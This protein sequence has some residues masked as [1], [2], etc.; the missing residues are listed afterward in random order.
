MKRED[1]EFMSEL[2]VAV[3]LR[4]V[5][6]SNFL[7]FCV[8]ALFGW[9]LLWVSYAEIEER[10]RGTGQ[11]MA[12]SDMQVIQSL[13]GGILAE[14][15]VSEGDQVKKGQI[16]MRI[17]DVLF[18]SEGRGIEAQMLSLRAKQAR[19]KAEAKGNA[20]DMP[21]DI[22]EKAPAIAAN[23]IKLYK[24]RAQELKNMLDISQSEIR[25]VQSNLA[26]VN[27]SIGK[28]GRSRDL[29]KKEFNIAV[30]LVAKHAM[31]EIEKIRLERSLNEASGDLA[32]AR[33]SARGF[34]AKLSATKQKMEEKKT[35]LTSKTLGELGEVET[36]IATIQQSLNS[37]EDRVDRTELRAPV[38]GIVQR[39]NLK[40]VGGVVEPAQRL[41]E[42]VP[43]EDDLMIRAKV[44]PADV[45]FLRPGQK[46]R[47]GITAYDPQI[48][49]SLT[50]V[51]E[52]ISADT[53]KDSDGNVF[54]EIDVRTDKNYLGH[55]DERLRIAPGMVADT[56]IITGK[57]TILT[58]LLKPLLR[59]RDRAFSER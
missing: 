19:L 49:G 53:V 40:T 15:M 26:E 45:A 4:P 1:L 46:V 57:R 58:Y 14:L 48:Y 42:V 30:R 5:F 41:I 59:A 10:T 54:F 17:D 50:G 28:L 56:E 13:E 24:S 35:A 37:V 51:L 32:T 39:I 2:D 3:K 21:K 11:V 27:T 52:R 36:R 34:K 38:D 9:G 55:E 18:A 20:F 23:E 8:V 29:L 12:S 33:E 6:A 25:E 31:P 22:L 44:S 47:V 7:L 43:L 16:L